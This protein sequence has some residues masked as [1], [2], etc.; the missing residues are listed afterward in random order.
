[1][2]EL[3]STKKQLKMY[4]EPDTIAE[5]DLLG[6]RFQKSKQ[7]IVEDLINIYLPVWKAV[8]INV[9]IAVD[10]QVEQ[11]LFNE[12]ETIPVKTEGQ[13]TSDIVAVPQK[14]RKRG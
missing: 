10:R 14:R 12:Q 4:L 3:M 1:M 9:R 6:Q 13:I 11:V 5:L 7:D 8:Q 2:T